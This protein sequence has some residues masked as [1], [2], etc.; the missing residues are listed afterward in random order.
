GLGLIWMVSIAL[1]TI[2]IEKGYR[3]GNKSLA[4]Y[5]CLYTCYE[6]L[7]DLTSSPPRGG[8]PTFRTL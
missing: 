3:Y 8:P 6:G 2:Y 5:L 4:P 7:V 1:P